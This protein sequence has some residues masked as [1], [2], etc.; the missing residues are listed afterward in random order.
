[1]TTLITQKKSDGSVRRCHAECYNAKNEKCT[2]ICGGRNHGAGL[3]KAAQ[4]T[5]DAIL[6]IFAEGGE[7]I[8]HD[9]ISKMYRAKTQISLFEPAGSEK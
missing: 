7:I 9:D 4:N 3:M 8:I 2:C 6:D 5:G 1:M